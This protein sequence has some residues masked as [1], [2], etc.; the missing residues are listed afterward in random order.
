MVTRDNASCVTVKSSVL[1]EPSELRV[2]LSI[3]SHENKHLR[4]KE[5]RKNNTSFLFIKYINDTNNKSS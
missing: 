2:A 1:K 3:P 4:V 5:E